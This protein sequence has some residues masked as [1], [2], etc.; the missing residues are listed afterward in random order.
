MDDIED[1]PLSPPPFE[2]EPTSS[3]EIISETETV[4]TN[5]SNSLNRKKRNTGARQKPYAYSRKGGNTTNLI[6]HLRDKHKITK[7][8]YFQFLDNSN[9]PRRDQ[10]QIIGYLKAAAP[11]SPKRQE[12]ITQKLVTFIIKFIQPL[13]ILQNQYFR[14]LLLIC[15]PGYRIPC[16]KTVKAIINDSFVC[17]KEQL[18]SLLNNNNTISAALFQIINEWH[19]SN[20]AFT[21]ATDNGSNM[22]KVLQ[23]LKQCKSIHHRVKCLQAFFRLPKQAQRLREAQQSNQQLLEEN[24]YSNPL[25]VLTDVKTRWN[26]TYYAWKRILELHNSMRLI[27]TTLLTKPDR[28]S[29]KEGE[30]LE[31]L[32]LSLDEKH[33]VNPYM[34]LLKKTFAPK[35]ENGESL[36]TY[37]DLIYGPQTEDNNDNEE[38]SDSSTSDDDEIPSGGS[39]QHWQYSHRTRGAI[40]DIDDINHVEYLPAVNTTGLL[41]KVQAAIFLSLDELWSVPTELVQ[42]ATVLDPQFKNFQWDRSG[43]ERDKSHQLL[44]ELYDFTKVDFES[45]NIQQTTTIHNLHTTNEDDNDDFFETLEIELSSFERQVTEE[46]ILYDSKLHTDFNARLTSELNTRDT[47]LNA[48]A[49][50]ISSS[51]ISLTTRLDNIKQVLECYN[52]HFSRISTKF[53]SINESIAT[54]HNLLNQHQQ[55]ETNLSEA[56]FNSPI[57]SASSSNSPGSS[58]SSS[59]SNQQSFSRISLTVWTRFKQI[60]DTNMALKGYNLDEMYCSVAMCIREL[61]E[62][63][64]PITVK[65]FYNRSS[66]CRLNTI[67]QIGLWIDNM[68]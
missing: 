11:C 67:D 4:T 44:Q 22:I 59:G 64:K 48:E 49:Q 18:C 53:D 39:R 68:E 42:I 26:S 29:Q 36:D 40:D 55:S 60:F 66:G 15:E 32:C 9:Q 25:D 45:N 20:T 8:N 54:F 51:I 3:I 7:E 5:S 62:S 16:D 52:N 47:I 2:Y 23:G 31:R 63:I 37:L 6:V 61:G 21:I 43:E 33:L 46:I 24:D 14:E 38:E 30:K 10:T 19:L 58:A 13:Y 57:S 56:S 65:N 17:C 1:I 35:S 50:R 27:S 34:E 12:L 41:Q 28:A